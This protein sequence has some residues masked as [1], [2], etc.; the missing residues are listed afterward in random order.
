MDKKEKVLELVKMKEAISKGEAD[1][2]LLNKLNEVIDKVESI[3][4]VD[5]TKLS[6]EI[7]ALQEKIEEETVLEL[8]II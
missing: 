1:F 5:L 6:D 3:P 8:E 2:V 4:E 7:K